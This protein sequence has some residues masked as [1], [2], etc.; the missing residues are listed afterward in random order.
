MR[1]IVNGLPPLVDNATNK[2]QP[3]QLPKDLLVSA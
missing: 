3:E 2:S 1:E